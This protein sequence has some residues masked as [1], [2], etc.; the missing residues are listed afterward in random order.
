VFAVRPMTRA[1]LS[2]QHG[3][4]VAEGVGD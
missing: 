2:G 4:G 3:V 1:K